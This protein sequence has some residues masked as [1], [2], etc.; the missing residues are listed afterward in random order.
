[1]R[2][3]KL[4]LAT[5]EAAISGLGGR[6]KDFTSVDKKDTDGLERLREKDGD[7]KEKLEEKKEGFIG[8]TTNKLEQ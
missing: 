1:L 8:K 3:F 4:K 2:K 7:L 6:D 5:T